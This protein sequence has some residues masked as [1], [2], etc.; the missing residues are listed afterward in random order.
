MAGGRGLR[1]AR[2]GAGRNRGPRGTTE[3]TEPATGILADHRQTAC[4]APGYFT[5][6]PASKGFIRAASAYLQAARQLQL[7]SGAP[8]G[9]GVGV[10]ALEWA[11]A[12]AQVRR[13]GPG[14]GGRRLKKRARALHCRCH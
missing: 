7:L 12:I 4:P 6:R 2:R 10:D 11:V 8:G 5:S 1:G 9:P 3:N 14:P 13:R